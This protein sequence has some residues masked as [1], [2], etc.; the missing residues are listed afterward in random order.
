MIEARMADGT[1]LRFPDGTPDDVIDRAARD[2]LA[3]PQ[4]DTSFMGTLGGMAQTGAGMADNTVRTLARGATLGFADELAAGANAAVGSVTG[5][6]G[7]FSERYTQ[8]LGQERARD[9]AFDQANPALSLAGQ[10]AGGAMMGGPVLG[11]ARSLAGATVRGAGTGA[12]YGTVAGFGS[13]EGGVMP[14]LA[15]AGEGAVIGAGIGA[16]LPALGAGAAAGAGVL[17]RSLNPQARLAEPQRIALRDLA[18][19]NVAPEDLLARAREAGP[20]PVAVADLAG[21]N[22]RGLAQ[23]IAR[24]PGDGQQ[25]ARDLI[26]SRGGPEQAGRLRQTIQQ[27]ISGDDFRTTMDD[28]VRTRRTAA[29]SNYARAYAQPLPNDPRLTLFMSDP[30]V[31]R[32]MMAGMD[33][34][35]REAL[36]DGVPFNPQEY[37]FRVQDGRIVLGDGP[38]PTQLV[39]AAKRGLDRLEQ[40]ARGPLGQATSESRE[41]AGVR[42]AM[43]RVAD[44][45]NPD[46]ATARQAFAGD[47]AMMDAA[48]TGRRLATMRPQDFERSA[49]ELRALS[50]G[51]REFLRMGFAR[52]LMDRINSAA[53][54]AEATRLRQVFGTPQIRER[55]AAT[56]D[57]P[58]DYARFARAMEQEIGITQTNRAIDPRGGSPTMPM[59]ERLAD[60]GRPPPGPVAGAISSGD[61]GLNIVPLARNV[62]G[63]GGPGYATVNLMAQLSGNR[64]SRRTENNLNSLARMLLTTREPERVA[65][66]E[67][68]LAR[69]LRDRAAA[70]LSRPVVRGAARGAGVVGGASDIPGTPR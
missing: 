53:D 64:G 59:T 41:L 60:V 38:V 8:N 68:L 23:V 48:E 5:Q 29:A 70:G 34:L 32:G 58:D 63:I 7:T 36:R 47:T 30:D 51:E 2:F 26:A 56:F 24:T 33:S 1:V 55:L 67:G 22:T 16:A 14:R 42:T 65:I 39:D 45:L 66:A 49:A 37:G 35:R 12:G 9:A 20:S 31:Q 61:G 4:T 18:R 15:N 19:D 54:G 27:A 62:M 6:P 21:E 10:V 46:F 25:I 13:G 11:G 28:L 40:S 52:G 3:T 44:E 17:A 57:N 50:P 69:A 43:L